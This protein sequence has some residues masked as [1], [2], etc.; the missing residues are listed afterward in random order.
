LYRRFSA[1]E[2]RAALKTA[3]QPL[4]PE[5]EAKDDGEDTPEKDHDTIVGYTTETELEWIDS[6][7][8]LGKKNP[9]PK[10]RP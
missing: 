10:K 5:A 7:A 2:I 6:P 9:S 1:A 3:K 8:I 4:R